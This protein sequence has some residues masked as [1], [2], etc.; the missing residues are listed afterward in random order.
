MTN[1]SGGESDGRART[2]SFGKRLRTKDAGK[3][4][5]RFD[6][7]IYSNQRAKLCTLKVCQTC[8]LAVWVIRAE[9]TKTIRYFAFCACTYQKTPQEFRNSMEKTLISSN[10]QKITD[11]TKQKIKNFTI[12]HIFQN[13]KKPK[14]KRFFLGSLL[15]YSTIDPLTQAYFL[16][17]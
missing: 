3:G 4:S 6:E 5:L 10:D 14:A 9:R 8:P 17:V 1:Q 15:H 2:K 7:K 11:L 13:L 16:C 12:D